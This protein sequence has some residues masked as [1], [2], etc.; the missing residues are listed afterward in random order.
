MLRTPA[1]LLLSLLAVPT[2]FAQATWI[3][4]SDPLAGPDFD[5]I[6]A[7]IDA[8]AAGDTILV[9]PGT[10]H[11]F[12]LTK[13]LSI[14]GS[15]AV[16]AGGTLS[17]TTVILGFPTGLGAGFVSTV[18]TDEVAALADLDF[19]TWCF[20]RQNQGVVLFDRCFGPV[21]FRGNADSRARAGWAAIR[22]A[23]GT[24]WAEVAE[25]TLGVR[26]DQQSVPASNPTVLVSNPKLFGFDAWGSATCFSSQFYDSTPGLSADW[27]DLI[28]TGLPVDFLI[29]GDR[30]YN[31]CI[32]LPGSPGLVLEEGSLRLSGVTV[33]AQDPSVADLGLGLTVDLSEPPTPDPSLRL[34]GEPTAGASVTLV[35]DGAAGDEARLELGEGPTVLF[36]GASA[37]PRLVTPGRVFP[38]G[39]VP[40][41]GSAS[42][43]LTIPTGARPGTIYWF[44]AWTTAPSGV[45]R[46]TNSLPLLI[47]P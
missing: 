7:A 44:Q 8:A 41:S 9:G 19:D 33:Q 17:P 32:P 2:S 15:V 18:A 37:V 45:G 34:I 23:D 22:I 42:V 43:T 26:V 27:A 12:D 36:T 46:R 11:R 1:M 14:V 6:Q 40:A 16:N 39:V 21:E 30:A 29:G 24:S 25:P 47:R 20:A 35:V 5:Q 31:S 38:M 13:G 3:V 28:V 4:D 10:Y